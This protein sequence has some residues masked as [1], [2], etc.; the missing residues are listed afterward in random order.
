MNG[1]VEL[2]K[3]LAEQL[4]KA[5]LSK[6]VDIVIA[7]P[8][9]YIG[10]AAQENSQA[11]V[12][13]AGQNC[14]LKESG[15]Y[16]GEVSPAMLRDVGAK[17]VILG[18][19]ERRHILGESSAFIAEKTKFAIKEGLKVILCVGE[20]KEEREANKTF[21][22]VSHQT[23]AVVEVLQPADWANVVIAYEP[24]WA[25]GTGLT[26]TP[27]DAQQVHSELRAYLSK[28]VSPDVANSTRILY[29]GSVNGKTAPDLSKEKDIDGF[30]VGGAS[31]KPE[32]IDIINV[33]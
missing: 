33:V 15:A 28:A 32:F 9:P 8:F 16:T 1:S 4:N 23:K 7:P 19:S 2:I 6:N 12:E 10:L 11:S 21:D 25:I 5:E 24:V 13:V 14:Y 18:H 3:K 20:K 22:V 31:L 17:W 26:A 27:S 30:L 29:G